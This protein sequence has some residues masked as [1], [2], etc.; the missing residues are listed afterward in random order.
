MTNLAIRASAS[1][2]ELTG[3][4]VWL[5]LLPIIGGVALATVKELS[6]AWA[7]LLGA[8]VSDL[9]LAL[10]NVLSKVVV[11]VVVVLHAWHATWCRLLWWW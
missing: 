10:R 2:A 9:A 6:F 5:S 8:I 4:Q 3:R 7:A 1:C 11:V